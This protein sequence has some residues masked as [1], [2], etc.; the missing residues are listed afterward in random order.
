MSMYINPLHLGISGLVSDYEEPVTLHHDESPRVV[1]DS[2]LYVANQRASPAEAQYAVFRSM[3]PTEEAGPLTDSATYH[4][5][6]SER[7]AQNADA[8]A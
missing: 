5:F 8:T 4:V 6:R 2:E 3:T 1:M 7:V